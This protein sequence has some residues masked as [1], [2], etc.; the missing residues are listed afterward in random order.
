MKLTIIPATEEPLPTTVEELLQSSRSLYTIKEMAEMTK[1]DRTQ[2][3]RWI[4]RG[5]IT[6]MPLGGT[7]RVY[8]HF[9]PKAQAAA[10]LAHAQGDGHKRGRPATVPFPTLNEA[11]AKYAAKAT[12]K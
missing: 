11:R 6:T 2:I 12:K 5:I 9:I 1:R 7:S 4:K 3:V 10:M 8:M